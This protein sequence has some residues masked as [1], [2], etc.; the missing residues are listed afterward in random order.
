MGPEAI[1]IGGYADRSYNIC[2][3]QSTTAGLL[4]MVCECQIVL[5]QMVEGK[6]KMHIC[7]RAARGDFTSLW[8]DLGVIAPGAWLSGSAGAG[9]AEFRSPLLASTLSA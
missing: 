4:V 8:P 5:L 6:K 7:Y 3:Q 2:Y 1:R 9:P